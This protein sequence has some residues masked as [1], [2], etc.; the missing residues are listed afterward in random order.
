MCCFFLFLV[1][2]SA[3][4]R[5]MIMIMIM[6]MIMSLNLMIFLPFLIK[7]LQLIQDFFLPW[8]SRLYPPTRPRIFLMWMFVLR[9]FAPT[10]RISIRLFTNI[11][12]IPQFQT[13][14]LRCL[15][16]ISFVMIVGWW[17]RYWQF[18][19]FSWRLVIVTLLVNLHNWLSSFLLMNI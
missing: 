10:S 18:F 2:G 7:L 17:S 12:E 15:A 11:I 8:N 3:T 1:L 4:L 19:E 13:R 5:R 16:A 6:V 14:R 9:N